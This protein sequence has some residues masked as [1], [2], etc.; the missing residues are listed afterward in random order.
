MAYAST[1]RAPDRSRA[2]IEKILERYGATSFAY[3]WSGDIAVIQLA[4][5]YACARAA[6]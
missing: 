1:T 2:E 5:A 3:G 6:G 4:H